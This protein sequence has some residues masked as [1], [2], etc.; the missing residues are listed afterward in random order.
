[1]PD[2]QKNIEELTRALGGY[3]ENNKRKPRSASSSS[4]SASGSEDKPVAPPPVSSKT[5]KKGKSL[6]QALQQTRQKKE[7][8]CSFCSARQEI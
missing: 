2:I 3:I 6:R 7:K 8:G 5:E 4:S 1:M